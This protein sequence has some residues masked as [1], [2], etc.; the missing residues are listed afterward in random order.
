MATPSSAPSPPVIARDAASPSSAPT[1]SAARRPR[2]PVRTR[3]D[4]WLD[5]ALLVAFALDYSFNFTGLTIHEWIGL[6]FGVALLVHVTLHWD[7]ALRTTKRLFKRRPGRDGLRWIVDLALMLVMTL[8]VAS[9]V[10]IS[11]AALP[12]IGITPVAGPFWTGLHTTSADVTVAL[13]GLHVALS[14][15]W[16]LTVGK[17]ILR[18]SS[19]ARAQ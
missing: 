2:V 14:W 10:L 18:R 8:C 16:I 5:L 4:F 15:R 11:R 6:G 1:R 3:I 19:T 17:R 9:G 7:W 13:V 12:A